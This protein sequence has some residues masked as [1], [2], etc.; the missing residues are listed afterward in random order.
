MEPPL[1]VSTKQATWN[2]LKKMSENLDQD[3]ALSMVDKEFV[4]EGVELPGKRTHKDE[5]VWKVT[6]G[7]EIDFFKYRNKANW[8][9]R[10]IKHT[11][12]LIRLH[13]NRIKRG[14]EYLY[15]QTHDL[16]VN[17]EHLKEC[18][19]LPKETREIA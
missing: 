7:E 1:S 10:Q 11:S 17:L 5:W 2:T 14:G 3:R 18:H 8:A 12:E 4:K 15:C 6:N 16:H 19:H 13:E 9:K